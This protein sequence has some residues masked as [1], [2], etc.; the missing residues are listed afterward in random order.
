MN[1]SSFISA[2]T[3]T[4]VYVQTDTDTHM[5]MI[6]VYVNADSQQIPAKVF[7]SGNYKCADSKYSS[8]YMYISFYQTLHNTYTHTQSLEQSDF[9][10][11]KFKT[12]FINPILRR[13][14]KTRPRPVY[15]FSL[16]FS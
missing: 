6:F 1:F 15:I 13:E 4:T 9:F 12:P 3:H 8:F 10:R 2:T 14:R 16:L 11:E 7:F 5:C